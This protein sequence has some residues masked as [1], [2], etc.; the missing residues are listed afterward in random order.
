MYASMLLRGYNGEF[1]YDTKDNLSG[2]GLYVY[3]GL[4]YG[5]FSVLGLSYK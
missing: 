5:I 3:G 4:V 1:Y 2:K